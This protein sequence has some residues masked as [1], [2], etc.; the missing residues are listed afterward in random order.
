MHEYVCGVESDEHE[1]CV[2]WLRGECARLLPS[3]DGNPF[4]LLCHCAS[5][6]S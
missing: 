4:L 5:T 3:P 6:V 2:G 1:W